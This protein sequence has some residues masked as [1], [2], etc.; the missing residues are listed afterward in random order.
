MIVA[1]TNNNYPK[2]NIGI[3]LSRSYLYLGLIEQTWK[4]W[5]DTGVVG[6]E[7]ELALLLVMAGIRGIRA[8]GIFASDGTLA[9][10][11]TARNTHKAGYDPHTEE[12]VTNTRLMVQVALDA[13]VLLD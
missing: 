10:A 12:L 1:S 5:F 2:P 8:G 7:M 9:N 3:L 6:V 13:L 4:M 11:D